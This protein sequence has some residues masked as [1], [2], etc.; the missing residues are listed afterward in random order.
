M[1]ISNNTNEL[2][3]IRCRLA[4]KNKLKKSNLKTKKV[5]SSL[6][7]IAARRQR[8]FD[9]HTSN[10]RYTENIL[11]NHPEKI[12]QRYRFTPLIY[13]F[14]IISGYIFVCGYF[15][16]IAKHITGKRKIRGWSQRRESRKRNKILKI[17]GDGIR[18]FSV[19]N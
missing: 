18:F 8:P 14:G 1:I 2:E 15:R 16:L 7:Y 6:A 5:K 3:M 10:A 13:L 12:N 19:Q 17:D 4:R 11:R 9:K